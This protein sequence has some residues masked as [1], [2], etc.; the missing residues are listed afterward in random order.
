MGGNEEL[1]FNRLC[2]KSQ[3]AFLLAIELYNRPTI[4]YRALIP[5]FIRALSFR[6]QAH[7][8]MFSRPPLN[9]SLTAGLLCAA[10]HAL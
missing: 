7:P 8:N 3:E 5:N 4:K 10:A 9:H 1:A 2:E 6:S